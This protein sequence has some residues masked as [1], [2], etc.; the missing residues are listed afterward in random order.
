MEL[1]QEAQSEFQASY[2]ILNK[3][4]HRPQ[5]LLHIEDTFYFVVLF[6]YHNSYRTVNHHPTE[7][8]NICNYSFSLSFISD[9][10]KSAITFDED[11]EG[12]DSTD[13]FYTNISGVTP[14]D[15]WGIMDGGVAGNIATLQV[16]NAQGQRA[17]V[18]ADFESGTVDFA[19]VIYRNTA[20]RYY[21]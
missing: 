14:D 1:Q 19:G 3:T 12:S 7:H 8:R 4:L 18:V 21:P 20:T 15:M 2:H 16:R 10:G 5:F 11:K 9:S 6:S 17:K 13:M